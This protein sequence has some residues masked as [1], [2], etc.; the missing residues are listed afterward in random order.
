MAAV[1]DRCL[2]PVWLAKSVAPEHGRQC[3]IIRFSIF[4]RGY[5][6]DGLSLSCFTDHK[7]TAFYYINRTEPKRH[8]SCEPSETNV[9]EPTMPSVV[10]LTSE[11]NG[12]KHRNYD[13][14]Q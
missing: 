3:S 1:F 11:I 9:R 12:R 2:S 4:H 8:S 5:I 14:P 13:I 7:C 10:V 6:M